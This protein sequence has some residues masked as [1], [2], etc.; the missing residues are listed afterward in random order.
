MAKDVNLAILTTPAAVTTGIVGVMVNTEGGFFAIVR[1]VVG[2]IVTTTSAL[3]D[4]EVS[5]NNGSNYY[6]VGSFPVLGNA[7]TLLG[8]IARVVY[9]PKVAT[10]MITAGTPYTKVRVYATVLTTGSCTINRVDVEPLV[11]LAPPAIDSDLGQG[12]E[13]L[14]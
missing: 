14:W 1:V 4:I 5:I 8:N 10:A 2:A 3:L 6:K 12:L 13:K 11:S 9:I 7:H